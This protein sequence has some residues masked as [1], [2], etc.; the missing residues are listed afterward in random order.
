V[1]D[2][3]IRLRG[4]A[5]GYP[6]RAVLTGVDLDV[7][8]GEL[9]VL[10]GPNG[11]GK[12]TLLAVL[13][14]MVLPHAGSVEVLGRPMTTWKR[15]E[16]ARVVSVLPQE[17]TLP[18]GLRVAEVV[19]LGRLPHARSAFGPEEDDE[20]VVA[21]AL[22]D[23]DARELAQR[24]VTELSGGERQRVLLALALAQEPRIL[25]L[26]EPTLHL[27]VGHQ[28]ALLGL[29][30]RLR[31]TRDLTVVAVLHDLD[32][33]AR[34]ADRVHLL[35]DG[36]LR[37]AS[38]ADGSLDLERVGRAFGVPLTVARTEEGGTV[39]AIARRHEAE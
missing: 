34:S 27:D 16:L 36:R 2:P 26:D 13:A 4:V 5:A 9:A 29:L 39:V 17:L 1:T 7:E 30:D 6:G 18:A 21:A 22:D 23:A 8:R 20:R 37:P 38:S 24:P 14:G 12:S 35:H 32:L 11:S 10:V 15:R 33:A 28:L 25:L 19:A 3:I 31:R